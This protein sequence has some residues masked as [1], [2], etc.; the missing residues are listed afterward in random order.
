MK[1]YVSYES[2]YDNK[3]MME[4]NTYKIILGFKSK[5]EIY[6]HIT[7]VEDINNICRNF[8]VRF[9]RFKIK[10]HLIKFGKTFC[11]YITQLFLI[12]E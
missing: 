1:V 5:N 4:I 12:R 6:I 10:K 2:N 11:E 8:S 9:I 3:N 7:P